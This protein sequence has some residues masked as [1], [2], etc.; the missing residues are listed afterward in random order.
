MPGLSV[1]VLEFADR[2]LLRN[3]TGKTVTVYGYSGE[4]Y[5]RVLPN[6]AAEQN[7][8]SPGGLPE[9]QL[10]RQRDRP[11]VGQRDA[12]RRGGKRSIAPAS[13]NGTTTASTG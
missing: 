7:R 11:A 9:H 12:R 5:A 1:E 10:L 3:G 8:R 6:G 4:P 2:L 13:S